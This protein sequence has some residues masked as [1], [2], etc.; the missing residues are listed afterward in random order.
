MPI[1]VFQSPSAI[2]LPSS[3]LWTAVVTTCS[4]PSGDN[5]IPQTSELS[6]RITRTV[7]A[8]YNIYIRIHTCLNFDEISNIT[9]RFKVKVSRGKRCR[10]ASCQMSGVY[11]KLYSKTWTGR[12]LNII[13]LSCN[14]VKSLHTTQN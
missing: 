14:S 4:F 12:H 3:E 5:L 1:S 11:V 8:A 6:K 9:E 10:V 13:Y 2:H 7:T